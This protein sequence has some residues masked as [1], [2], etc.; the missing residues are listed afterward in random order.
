MIYGFFQQKIVFTPYKKIFLYRRFLNRMQKL[1]IPNI[2]GTYL[3][4]MLLL[5]I[6]RNYR[7][8]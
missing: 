4:T 3:K 5:R 1:N 6:I 7:Q 2:T 8:N